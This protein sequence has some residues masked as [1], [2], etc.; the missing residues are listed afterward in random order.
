M[1]QLFIDLLTKCI[2]DHVDSNNI[3]YKFPIDKDK[4]DWIDITWL[5]AN[6]DYE[7]KTSLRL[8]FVKNPRWNLPLTADKDHK[9]VYVMTVNGVDY[10]IDLNP[11]ETNEVDHLVYQIFQNYQVSVMSRIKNWI[12]V[13]TEPETTEQKFEAAQEKVA[14]DNGNE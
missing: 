6:D 4:N 10:I 7:V 2:P 5:K 3:T 13:H 9:R 1:K 12:R 11:V 14:E 8:P